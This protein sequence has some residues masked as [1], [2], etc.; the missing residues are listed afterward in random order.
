M[1]PQLSALVDRLL[2]GFR[3]Q[4]EASVRAYA[5]ETAQRRSEE[6]KRSA[7][8]QIAE[9]R[10]MLEE[11]R[12]RAH[13][14]QTAVDAR[15]AEAVRERDQALT[16]VHDQRAA[17]YSAAVRLADDMRALSEAGSLTVVFERLIDAASRRGDR[18]ALLMAGPPLRRWRSCGFDDTGDGAEL[19]EDAAAMIGAAVRLARVVSSREG[20]ASPAFAAAPSP[21][22]AAAF[23]IVLAG[24]VVAVLYVDLVAA[25]EQ[26]LAAWPELEALAR[27]AGTALEV[28]TLRHTASPS[29]PFVPPGAQIASSSSIAGP[30]PDVTRPG[31]FGGLQ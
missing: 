21:V 29:A 13:E 4:L 1:D 14:H 20:A 25:D 16:R 8:G 18:T 30:R 12:A 31:P 6:L 27:H 11:I 23:P 22:D 28:V 26:R 9:L 2:A 7:E 10:T 19:R 15:L 5:D 24:D 3:G 17:T